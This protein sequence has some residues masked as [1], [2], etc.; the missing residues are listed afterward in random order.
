M[1]SG[2]WRFLTFCLYLDDNSMGL[3]KK[4]G[5]VQQK[6]PLTIKDMCATISVNTNCCSTLTLRGILLIDNVYFIMNYNEL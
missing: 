6:K 1:K 4:S 2:E 3:T 5:L